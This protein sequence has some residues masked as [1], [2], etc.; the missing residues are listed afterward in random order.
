[1]R[2]WLVPSNDASGA[3]SRV[4]QRALM[5]LTE[6]A[7]AVLQFLE[8]LHGQPARH[9]DPLLL[10]A[11]RMLGRSHSRPFV[12]WPCCLFRFAQHCTASPRVR[13]TAAGYVL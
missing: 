11:V 10:A 3:G 4:A 1:M 8:A 7:E 2:G 5:S 6:A 9:G 13:L 12:A